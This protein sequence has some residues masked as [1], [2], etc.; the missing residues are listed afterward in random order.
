MMPMGVTS[1]GG[2]GSGGAAS[3][4]DGIAV[5]DLDGRERKSNAHNKHQQQS[6][7]SAAVSSVAFLEDLTVFIGVH[8]YA[9]YIKP[10]AASMAFAALAGVTNG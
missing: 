5:K 1:R 7:G 9:R 2:L 4:H 3:F 8:D 10:V 6:D